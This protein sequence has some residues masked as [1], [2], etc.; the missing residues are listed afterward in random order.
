M[1]DSLAA[2]NEIFMN[3]C[4]HLQVNHTYNFVEPVSG[5]HTQSFENLWGRLKKKEIKKTT[6]LL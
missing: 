6:V 2:Y 4:T 5:V 3:D 1:R